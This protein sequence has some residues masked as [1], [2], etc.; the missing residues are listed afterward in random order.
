[1]EG[2][3]AV[4]TRTA[5]TRSWGRGETLLLG[6]G[7]GANPPAARA[8]EGIGYPCLLYSESEI[9]YIQWSGD[10]M[11]VYSIYCNYIYIFIGVFPPNPDNPNKKAL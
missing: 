1:M 4:K 3:S 7:A 10:L 5:M 6:L 11:K 2:V 9:M 8:R